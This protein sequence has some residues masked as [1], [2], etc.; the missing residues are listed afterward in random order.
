M[1]SIRWFAAL[2]FT[3]AV[4]SAPTAALAAPGQA[5]TSAGTAWRCTTSGVQGACGPYSYRPITNS[6]GFT[7]YVLNHKWACDSTNPCGLQTVQANTPGNWQVTSNQAAGH[8]SVLTYP[9]VQQLF[10]HPNNA[11]S[12]ISS[13]HAIFSHFSEAIHATAGTDAEAAYDIWLSNTQGPNEVMIWVDNHGRGSG[14]ATRIGHAT[15]FK[16]PFT[17][18]KYGTG[19]IIFSL[20]HNEQTGTAHILASL[21]W[22]VQH[23]IVSARTAIGQVDFG[24]EICSTGGRPETFTISAYSL[25]SVCR[26]RGCG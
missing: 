22:L 13:F 16:Q 10:T 4:A 5:V 11:S 26:T 15:I 2:I 8:T 17:V 14:G 9:D 25:Q 19:E 24:W 21:Y 18:Y 20:D 6:H 1:R 23:G 7:T 12:P 3:L